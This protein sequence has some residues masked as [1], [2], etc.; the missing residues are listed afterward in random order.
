M[1]AFTILMMIK[2]IYNVHICWP[3]PTI[4]ATGDLHVMR[5]S[6]CEFHEKS[7]SGSHTLP[8]GDS[9]IFVNYFLNFF[10]SEMVKIRYRWTLRAADQ[11]YLESFEMWCWRRMEKI[12]WTDHV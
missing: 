9:E 8:K 10:L 3:I 2:S 6:S 7:C 1:Y 5:L 11:K 4:F 12:S